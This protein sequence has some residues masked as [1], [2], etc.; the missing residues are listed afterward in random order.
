M[1]IFNPGWTFSLAYEVEISARLGSRLLFKMTLQLRVNE[2][3]RC[4][5]KCSYMKDFKATF[6]KSKK[7]KPG[8]W[9]KQIK[10]RWL[11]STKRWS[12]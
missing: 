11:Q 2:L 1:E 5:K 10:A 9:Q 7:A 4:A 8:T 3:A 6:N 12:L